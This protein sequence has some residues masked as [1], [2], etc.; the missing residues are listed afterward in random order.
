MMNCPATTKCN[1]HT[2]GGKA[3]WK[4]DLEQFIAI[5]WHIHVSNLVD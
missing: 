2:Y 3:R 1:I 5:Q 4:A